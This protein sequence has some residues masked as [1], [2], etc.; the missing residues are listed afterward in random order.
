LLAA[1]ALHGS[2]PAIAG[3]IA[4]I[5][6]AG[7]ALAGRLGERLGRAAG[8]ALIIDYGPSR[9]SSGDSLQAVRG[10]RFADPLADPGR[11]DLTAHVDFAGLA[12]AARDAGAITWGPVPQ[13]VFLRRL[14]IESRARRLAEGAGDGGASVL[15]ALARLIDP[16]EM[17]TLF[18]ALALA[19]PGLPAPAGFLPED[20]RTTGDAIR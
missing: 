2:A 11:T 19:S 8:V 18:K 14:G 10:H 20:R 12:S 17:G 13:G 5:G 16:S 4:E 7:R 1:L 9:S 3:T 6:E 15:L